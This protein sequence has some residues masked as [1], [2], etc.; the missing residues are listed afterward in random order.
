MADDI[1]VRIIRL[2]PRDVSRASDHLRAFQQLIAANEEKYPAI[3][4]W[5]RQKVFD[6][7]RTG[8]RVAFVGYQGFRPAISAVVKRGASS[9]FCH[10]R[11]DDG[12]HNL[13]LGEMFFSMMATEVKRFATEVHFTLPE[14]LWE[15]KS[16]FFKGFGFSSVDVARTQYRRGESE[17]RC[18]APYATVWE[19][20]R[21]KLPKLGR[22]FRSSHYQLDVPLLLSIRP[23]HANAIFSG[24]KRIEI[25][26]RFSQRWSGARAV[27]LATR[28]VGAL[29][30]EVTI[31]S[32][33][34]AAP[35]LIWQ[36]FSESIGCTQA[37]FDAYCAG[38]REVFALE[39][40]DVSPY[41]SP[42]PVR[43][44]T[45]L[46]DVE[47]HTPQS[48]ADLDRSPS[49]RE[50]VSLS[51]MLHAN[52]TVRPRA[53]SQGTLPSVVMP[54][55]SLPLFSRAELT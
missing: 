46:L 5:L 55:E 2:T 25:R 10:L 19:A 37:E 52:V 41:L 7:V 13:S 3:G 51:A 36:H 50:A 49:W 22:L 47:L 14:S 8:E 42:V 18:S 16:Q 27:V 34:Q 6:G 31:E 39:L 40:S 30:G 45:H 17:L 44:L 32:V 35:A 1:D 4:S 28:P 48:Y 38:A 24:A 53:Q 43:Q 29:L 12:L 21:R 54:Q 11:I 9:K 23:R 26:R 20:T 33:R 15:A